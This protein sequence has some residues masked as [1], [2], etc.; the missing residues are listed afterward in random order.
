M[1]GLELPRNLIEAARIEHRDDWLAHLDDQVAELAS[2]W[3]LRLG[4][5][6]QPGGQTAWVAPVHSAAL[7]D[8]V[9]KVGWRHSEAEHE[10][11]GLRAWDGDGAV[12]V[13]ASEVVGDSVALLL[14]RCSPG[15]SLADQPEPEQDFVIAG[16][17][18]R[19]WRAPT[20]EYPFRSLQEMCDMWAD[21]FERKMSG[22]LVVLD[23][24][25]ARAGA[26]LFRTLP[27]TSTRDVL[28]CTDLHAENVLSAEREP[29]LVIDPKPYVGD[30]TYDALQHMLNCDAR[31]HADPRDLAGRIAELLELDAERL[32][33]WLF[34]RCVVESAGWPGLA[35]VAAKLAPR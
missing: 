31:L 32:R 13:H 27:G 19:L 35:D 20:H 14:E 6:Y 22:G 34:A 8:V 25:L 21:E 24:G 7:G 16:L 5:P 12:V 11:E 10:A 26:T 2:R 3:S 15:T 29:W 33:S 1:D 18:H 30:P 4:P 28:L 9:L 17:L 23:P